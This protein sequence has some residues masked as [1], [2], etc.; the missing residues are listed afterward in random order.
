MKE[1]SKLTLAVSDPVESMLEVA[2][3]VTEAGFGKLP[4]AVYRPLLSIEPHGA[5]AQ[6]AV[7][8]NDC[9]ALEGLAVAENC[10]WPL[11]ATV[12][13]LGATVTVTFTTLTCT[14]A[15]F[16]VSA[17][18]VA[19]TITFAVGGVEGA[20]YNPELEMVPQ[21]APVHPVLEMLHVTAVS[22]VPVTAALNC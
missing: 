19:L 13:V 9:G 18:K 17:F 7:Q 21:V 6:V 10:C 15:D 1:E 16:V 14:V 12:A 22:L 20:V 4:G 2:V 11:R 8:V 5:L 3:M